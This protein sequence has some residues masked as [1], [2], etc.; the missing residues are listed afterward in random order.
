MRF[1]FY[2]MVASALFPADGI[3]INIGIMQLSLFRISLFTIY[4]NSLI[5]GKITLL[6]LKFIKSVSNYWRTS[7]YIMLLMAILS[8]FWVIDIRGWTQVI[9]YLVVG[10]MLLSIVPIYI[11]NNNDMKLVMYIL[12]IMS[13]IHIAIGLLEVFQGIYMFS[14]MSKIDKYNQFLSN[15]SIRTPISIFGNTNN[16]ATFILFSVFIAHVSAS[17][18]DSRL[19]RIILF[20]IIGAGAFLIFRSNSRANL[21]AVS[22]F[23]IINLAKLM[24]KRLTLSRVIF[25][26]ILIII[27]LLNY[28]SVIQ[29]LGNSINNLPTLLSSTNSDNIRVNLLKNGRDFLVATF[30]LGVGAGNIEFWMENYSQ[31]YVSS[32]VNIHNWWAEILVSL[33]LGV[34]II[35]IYSYSKTLKFFFNKGKSNFESYLFFSYLVCFMISSTSSSTTLGSS[36]MWLMFSIVYVKIRLIEESG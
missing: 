15:S 21:I 31:Y 16:Y 32:I 2:V 26:Y 4:L 23:A 25:Y 27:A 6:P 28:R 12:L 8:I 18:T 10:N 36:W 35:H 19:F 22:L 5:S 11:R 14:D 30:G 34:F 1:L 3:S 17:T 9:F 24:R 20:S 29:L 13:A 7:F 33:G